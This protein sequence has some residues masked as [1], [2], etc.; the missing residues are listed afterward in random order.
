MDWGGGVSS[1]RV[2]ALQVGSPSP[3][4]KKKK[5]E[6]KKKESET[7]LMYFFNWKFSSQTFISKQLQ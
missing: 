1:S 7:L 2:P 4:K 3:T 6:R 5:K